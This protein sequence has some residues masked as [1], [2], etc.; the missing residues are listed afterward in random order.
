MSRLPLSPD[1]LRLI[2]MARPL[3]AIL[4]PGVRT[5]PFRLAGETLW[6]PRSEARF[7]E[8]LVI[9]MVGRGLLT[10]TQCAKGLPVWGKP[11][12]TYDVPFSVILSKMGVEQRA[13]HLADVRFRAAAND[14]AEQGSAAA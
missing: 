2:L 1:E 7:S 5:H 12:E 3:Q 14:T 10:V 13:M 9:Q 11:G 4:R 8:A 6:T